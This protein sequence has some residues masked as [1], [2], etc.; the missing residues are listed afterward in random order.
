MSKKPQPSPTKRE[1]E[2]PKTQVNFRLDPD[3]YAA[4]TTIARLE[5]LSVPKYVKQV[6]LRHL[7]ELEKEDLQTN[8]DE[9]VERMQS[10]VDGALEQLGRMSDS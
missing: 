3:V 1:S 5:G 4:V 8:I 7:A 10:D 6:F 9:Y 2:Q